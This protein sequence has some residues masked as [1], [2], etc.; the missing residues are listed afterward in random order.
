MREADDLVELDKIQLLGYPGDGA[1]S[2]VV[3][4]GSWGAGLA[5]NM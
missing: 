5:N 3:K 4:G 2:G 1:D